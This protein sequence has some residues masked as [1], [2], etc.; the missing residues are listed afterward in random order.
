MPFFEGLARRHVVAHLK[1]EYTRGLTSEGSLGYHGTSIYALRYCID[2]GVIPGATGRGPRSRPIEAQNGDLYFWRVGDL[3][4]KYGAY[5]PI[6]EASSYAPLIA[7][8]HHLIEL[9]G[10]LRD[11]RRHQIAAAEFLL[12]SEE[13]WRGYLDG[14]G[15]TMSA[16][17]IDGYV[18]EAETHRGLVVGISLEAQGRYPIVDVSAIYGDDGWRIETGGAGL[19]YNLIRGIQPVGAE[20]RDFLERLYS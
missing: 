17:E 18:E 6:R 20:A 4:D 16:E 5:D 7:Q 12:G 1:Q 13:F 10:L 9:L 15:L 14:V 11:N 8:G 19:P 2:H 3:R